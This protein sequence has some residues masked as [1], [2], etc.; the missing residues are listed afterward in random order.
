MLN[1]RRDKTPPLN[2][3][4][5][6]GGEGWDQVF[7]GQECKSHLAPREYEVDRRS[8]PLSELANLSEI[9][10]GDSTY[11]SQKLP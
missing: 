10:K 2:G 9:G 1:A 5:C 6:E 11:L 3:H 7:I 8:D 4:P